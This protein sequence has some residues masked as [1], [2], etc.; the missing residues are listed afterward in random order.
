[1]DALYFVWTT[2]MTVGY[3]DIALKDASDGVKLYGMA[4]MLAGAAFI[5]ILFALLLWTGAYRQ[6]SLAARQ[7][8]RARREPLADCRRRQHRLPARHAAC[9]ARSA[10]GGAGAR[11]A[12]AQRRS[13]RGG[14]TP[15]HHRRR[16]QRRDSRARRPALG[17]AAARCDRLG[18]GQP[19]ARVA[20]TRLRC[21]GDHAHQLRRTRGACDSARRRGGAS[22]VTAAVERFAA[23]ARVPGYSTNSERRTT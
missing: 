5:A 11:P 13:A 17:R 15:R 10:D 18:R 1:M 16:D 19:P 21:A 12:G 6:A 3:G 22:P 20:R 9:R 4:L 8:A 7:N 14:R 23:A 2:V